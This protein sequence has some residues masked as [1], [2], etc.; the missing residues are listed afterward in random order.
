[1]KMRILTALALCLTGIPRESSAAYTKDR[2]SLT[3]VAAG[4]KHSF[5]LEDG[6]VWGRGFDWDGRLGTGLPQAYLRLERVAV[7]GLDSVAAIAAGSEFTLARRTNGTVWAW[8]QN[9]FGQLG[10]GSHDATNAPAPVLGVSNNV[11]RN[12]SRSDTS[13][14]FEICGVRT[15]AVIKAERAWRLHTM[16]WVTVTN[17]VSGGRST[18]WSELLITNQPAA[19]YRVRVE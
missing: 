11:L 8:G 12:F 3:P 14:S 19:Y 18:H 16:H 2:L 13:T 4:S 9:Y 1:M 17:F 6:I 10:N 7:V 15:G 5:A